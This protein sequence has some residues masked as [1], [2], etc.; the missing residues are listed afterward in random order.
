MEETE[1]IVLKSFDFRE[2][3][4]IVVFF[5]KDFGII[6][7]LAKGCRANSKKFG[8]SLENFCY[9]YISFYGS[10]KSNL[11]LLGRCEVRDYFPGIRE[12]IFKS[13][14]VSYWIEILEGIVKGEDEPLFD[15]F[16]SCLKYL[17]SQEEIPP[18]LE[19]YF[20]LN[21]L[22][23]SGY[24]P[25]LEHC[26]NCKKDS[27]ESKFSAKLGGLLCPGCYYKDER[28]ISIP[29]GIIPILQFF[30]KMNLENLP[31]I[32]LRPKFRGTLKGIVHYYLF[33]LLEKRPKSLDFL[34]QLKR[35]K[36][37]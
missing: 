2:T 36:V 4:K 25:L 30:G 33:Y 32:K 21:V 7:G 15:F 17:D 18:L 26:V 22:R 6:K 11:H 1:G 9:D 29:P 35:D 14:L 10:K 8:F 34:E 28:A 23:I 24:S 37:K 20:E 5:T 12:D 3:S 13:T 19:S 16:I 31:R 27:K